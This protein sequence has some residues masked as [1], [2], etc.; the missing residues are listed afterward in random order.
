MTLFP[1]AHIISA[2][3]VDGI[4]VGLLDMLQAGFINKWMILICSRGGDSYQLSS[5]HARTPS[6][7]HIN[8]DVQINSKHAAHNQGHT[9]RRMDEYCKHHPNI[10]LLF[11]PED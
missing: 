10:Q 7:L 5:L 11:P 6:E 3:N 1:L 9:E 2:E 4:N 8:Q